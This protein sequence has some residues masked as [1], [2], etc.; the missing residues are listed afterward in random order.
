MKIAS[1]A[2]V[3]ARLNAYLDECE[4]KGP[5]IITRNG[6]PVAVLL[7][8]ANDD[9][10]ENLVLSRSPRFKAILS[11]SRKSIKAGRGLSRNEF[12][13]AVRKLNKTETRSS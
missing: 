2:D 6:K 3:K 12:W 10:L 4:S 9:D 13:K 5:V 11:K 7:S 8:P 1:V